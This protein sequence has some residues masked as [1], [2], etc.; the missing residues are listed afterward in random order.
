MA[1]LADRWRTILS[2]VLIFGLLAAVNLLPPDTSLAE[3]RAAGVLRA[4]LP[5]VYPPLVTG[6]PVAPG[7]D[8]ELLRELAK[9]M[10]LRLA[11][12][13][14]PAMGRDFNPRNWHIT[15]AQCDVLAGGVVASPQTRSFLE[16]SPSYAETG[17]AFVLPKPIGEQPGGELAGRHAGV[18]V[19]I[20][21]LDRLALSRF[22]REQKVEVTIVS[23]AAELA[24]GLRD[25]KF[26]FGVTEFLLAG[27]IA[28]REGWK[29]EWAP[30]PLVHY[31]LVLGLWKGDLT[32]KRAIVSSLDK[33]ERNGDVA[34]IMSRYLSGDRTAGKGPTF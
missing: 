17:W 13:S 19:G 2:Y 26:D 8:I 27:R 11:V 21:G 1:F 30:P 14:N 20:S 22:L 25:G 18:L 32:L 16:T 9:G 33:L 28:A 6:D 12:S 4:C 15:R 7:I 31:P 29:V 23:D 24:Q 34:A 5:S 10:D 3:V